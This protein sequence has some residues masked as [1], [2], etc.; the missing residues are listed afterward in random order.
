ME[1]GEERGR[2]ELKSV[3]QAAQTPP[4]TYL[5]PTSWQGTTITSTNALAP[6]HRASTSR[7]S[8]FIYFHFHF[9]LSHRLALN[10]LRYV[11]LYLSLR[12]NSQFFSHLFL[13]SCLLSPLLSFAFTYAF[14]C[15]PIAIAQSL[16]FCSPVHCRQRFIRI[17]VGMY[18][19]HLPAL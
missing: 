11:C 6:C 5:P 2:L 18:R 4:N 8:T 10:T 16:A 19:V 13:I 3:L 12:R 7:T 9:H 1:G 14:F 17:P 15:M